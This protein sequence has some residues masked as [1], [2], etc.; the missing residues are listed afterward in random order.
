MNKLDCL[1]H[2][3]DLIEQYHITSTLLLVSRRRD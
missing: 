1:L 2:L 3:K